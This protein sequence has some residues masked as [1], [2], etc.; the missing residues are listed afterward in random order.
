MIADEQEMKEAVDAI[1]NLAGDGDL[2]P[3]NGFIEVDRSTP[4]R[5]V[6]R[7][8]ADRLP[9]GG[10]SSDDGE[11]ADAA[12]L[13]FSVKYY[14]VEGGDG[15]WALYLPGELL[16]IG[17]TSVNLKS[18]LNEVTS[19]GDGW[20]ALPFLPAAGGTIYLNVTKSAG[21]GQI[22]AAFDSAAA[23]SSDDTAV[24][25]AVQIAVASRADSGAVT[26]RQA[27]TSALFLQDTDG[28]SVDLDSSGAIRLAHFDD[29]DRD[30]SKGLTSRLKA[31]A[32]SGELEPIGD[33]DIM[34]VARKKGQLIYVPLSGDGDDPQT[35]DDEAERTPCAHP[36]DNDNDGGVSPFDDGPGSDTITPS[37]MDGGVAAG[38]AE[39]HPGDDNCNCP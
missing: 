16:T 14:T 11:A 2:D 33:D 18:Q 30:S 39:V 8:R 37:G 32:S 38:S 29:T 23:E 34:F 35:E 31:N 36:G 17:S 10:G 4:D 5:P 22:S 3:Q 27:V 26:V 24:V 12:L 1:R 25:A 13:P 9:E 20:F 21:S 15:G 19:L 7:L 6:L 28:D